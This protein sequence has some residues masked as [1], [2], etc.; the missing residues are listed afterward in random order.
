MVFLMLTI[1]QT[2]FFKPKKRNEVFI[3]KFII[4]SFLYKGTN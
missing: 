4:K 2:G 1:K 3:I